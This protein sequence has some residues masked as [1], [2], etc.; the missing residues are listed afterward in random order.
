[1]C[2]CSSCIFWHENYNF[3]NV[4]I[5]QNI[6]PA[7]ISKKPLEVWNYFGLQYVVLPVS[8]VSVYEVLQFNKSNRVVQ[9]VEMLRKQ[10]FTRCKP[11]FFEWGHIMILGFPYL[12]QSS[13]L[14]I[15]YI[16]SSTSSTAGCIC[17][18]PI[19]LCFQ[20]HLKF[21]LNLCDILESLCFWLDIYLWEQEV[22]D[23]VSVRF[24]LILLVFA[25]SW[26]CVVLFM[27]FIQQIGFKFLSSLQ[28][29]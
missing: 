14:W 2:V 16:R 24:G 20:H 22:R 13:A 21:K 6:L 18:S 23:D 12:L 25:H 19:S 3:S 11:N 17:G 1:M 26:F 10:A 7:R 15:L 8:F 29:A 5:S 28:F 9:H 27:V 4:I